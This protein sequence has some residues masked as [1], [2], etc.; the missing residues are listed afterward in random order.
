MDLL[1]LLSGNRVN[2][3]ANVLGGVKFDITPEQAGD[4]L[5]GLDSWSSATCITWTWSAT[6]PCCWAVSG[7]W[8]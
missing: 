4:V 6:T 1:E 8:A 7:A 3:S 2:Y 5:K